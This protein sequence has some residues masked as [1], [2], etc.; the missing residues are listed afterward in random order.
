M[1]NR[2]PLLAF[3]L[4][5]VL[6]VYLA[7]ALGA[8][9]RM[10]GADTLAGCDISVADSLH[11]GFVSAAEVSRECGDIMQRIGKVRRDSVDI[12]AIEAALRAS[13]K[14]ESVNVCVLN[15]GT[16]SID[17][18]PMVPVARV[19]DI[20]SSY[21]INAEG[22]RISAEPRY[23]VDVPVV[24]GYFPADRPAARLLPLLDYIAADPE[25]DALVST[26]RQDR[27]GDIIIVPSIRGHVVNFGDTSM[28]AD[29]FARLW[30]F[31]RQV[32]PVR[33]WETYDTVSVKWRGRVTATRRH[34]NLGV[35]LLAA[36]VEEFDDIDDLDTMTGH[37]MVDS[38]LIT[39]N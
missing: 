27:S 8:T 16:L 18:V 21:Y 37:D 28:V 1:I 20:N 35:S 19:F 17:V 26:V 5:A 24:V 30:A 2:N 29:K 15:N 32:M 38:T 14:I 7:F 23:H 12:G 34:K 39:T 3:I 25:I 4:T 31:Y 10:A 9:S 33:G 36:T 11:T 22:K 6:A 13:D